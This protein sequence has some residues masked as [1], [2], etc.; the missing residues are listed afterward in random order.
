VTYVQGGPKF[1]S[2]TTG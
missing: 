2:Y 1:W